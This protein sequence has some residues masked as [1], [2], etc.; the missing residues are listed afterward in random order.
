MG[1][2]ETQWRRG[3]TRRGALA[4]LAGLFASSRLLRAHDSSGGFARFL[5]VN[6]ERLK[7]LYQR[8]LTRTLRGRPTTILILFGVIAASALRHLRSVVRLS[9]PRTA[10]MPKAPSIMP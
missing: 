7:R 9:A 10:P 8:A 1:K 3:L 5:D 6:F 4:G 2:I